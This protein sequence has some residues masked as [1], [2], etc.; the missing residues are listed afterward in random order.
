[1]PQRHYCDI[2]G[3]EVRDHSDT[4]STFSKTTPLQAP[5]TDP[6]TGLRYH[7]KSVY[8]L[9]KGLVSA[10]N[11]LIVPSYAN[12]LHYCFGRVRVRPKII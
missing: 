11:S 9:I 4:I 1:M 5:Y 10:D 7:D 3:L 12:T 6:V 8:E 2:T